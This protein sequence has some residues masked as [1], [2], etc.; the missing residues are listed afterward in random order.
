[1]WKVQMY[2]IGLVLALL[3]VPLG[4]CYAAVRLYARATQPPTCNLG[5]YWVD[6]D[7]TAGEKFYI[8]EATNTW[9]R[10][11]G[12][13]TSS[14][15]SFNSVHAS[16]GN[17]AAANAQVTKKW[18]T[19]LS[20]TADVTSVI[21]GGKHWIAKTTH[22]AG[23]TTEPGVGANYNDAWKEDTAAFDEAGDYTPTGSWD[24][25]GATISGF[26]I[27]YASDVDTTGW[28]NG[29]ILKFNASGNLVVA[30]D[31]TGSG[32]LPSCSNDQDLPEWDVTTEAW[33]CVSPV[34][35]TAGD[36]ITV[37][38]GQVGVT[39]G[40]F[41]APL[42]SGTNIKTINSQ[43]ILGSGD[44]TISGSSEPTIQASDPTSASSVGWYLATGSGDAFY[45][46]PAGLFNISAGTYT[47][48]PVLYTFSVPAPEH[49]NVS[50]S[51]ADLNTTINCGS[52][53][54]AC[55]STSAENAAITGC[56][57]TA[58]SGYEFSAWSGDLTGTVYNDGAV[59]MTGNKSGSATF[60][61][62]SSCM[63]GTYLFAWNGEHASG[64]GYACEGDGDP[65]SGTV[66][67]SPTISTAV[68]EGGADVAL[69]A[70]AVSKYLSWP[71]SAGARID[72]NGAQTVWMRVYV[73]ATPTGYS[74]IFT[75][76]YDSSNYVSIEVTSVR[77]IRG[78]HK[79]GATTG[80]VWGTGSIA[81]GAWVDI[82]YTWDRPNRNHSVN[83]SGSWRADETE[84]ST[85]DGADLTSIKIGPYSSFTMPA[86][87]NT[88][89]TK[90]AIVS[91][92]KA[93]K[94]W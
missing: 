62:L 70:D 78:Q 2:K 69:M 34:T 27:N 7:G 92:Y 65:V 41:Q 48:D 53:Y 88:R 42:V 15:P 84:L 49:G 25:S 54:S 72:L 45:K 73:S 12:Y 29:K 83:V 76:E 26:S 47:A 56:V 1:M 5:D 24:F 33:I 74:R 75:A 58:D 21:H 10:Q 4:D 11:V 36:N 6:T 60:T 93:A 63:S 85:S 13:G 8:C 17:L 68:G 30:D 3:S 87:E 39:P 55:S 35:I 79:I 67:G 61:A 14:N 51:D 91:G 46:S 22:T 86:N 52:G 59:T 38:N 19:G 82:A 20:Y 80:Q 9:V 94:P 16:G 43:S 71:D 77:E 31:S 37:T 23:S 50:C 90:Y 81:A 64:T 18:I 66:T 44:L 32:S 40:S 89:V 57:A 28:A